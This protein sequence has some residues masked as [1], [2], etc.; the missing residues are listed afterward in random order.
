LCQGVLSINSEA[1]VHQ[2][3]KF[4]LHAHLH[5]SIRLS[6][7]DE[8][9]IAAGAGPVRVTV[10]DEHLGLVEKPFELFP[11]IHKVVTSK[12]IVLRILRE[13]IEDFTAENVIYMEIRTTPRALP[14]GTSVTEYV[15]LLTETIAAHNAKPDRKVLVKLI[16]SVDRAK[17]LE[18]GMQVISLLRDYS[19]YPRESTSQ[20]KREK[21]IVGVDFSGNPLGGRFPEF[22]SIF[23][24]ARSLGFNITLHT[25]EAEDLYHEE[26]YDETDAILDFMP[27]RVGHMLYLHDRH[28]KKVFELKQAGKAIMVEICPST[29][30]FVLNLRSFSD[31]PFIRKFHSMHQPLSLNTDDTAI[32]NTTLTKEILHMMHALHW[33]PKDILTM[34]ARIIPHIFASPLEKEAISKQFWQNVAILQKQLL[35]AESQVSSIANDL[36]SIRE[37]SLDQAETNGSARDRLITASLEVF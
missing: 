6:T 35:Q 17:S 14:D 31:H 21:V 11:L 8:L 37:D 7:L 24:E 5:G 23:D 3:P 18:D 13:M 19:Y 2:L 27:D 9:N 4:E 29:S 34:Q 33:Q 10:S 25:A 30:F 20:V 1:I 32:F 16:L 22:R 28:L 15:R 36:L 26:L 12:E